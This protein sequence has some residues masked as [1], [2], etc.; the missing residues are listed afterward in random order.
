M[1]R[2]NIHKLETA[3]FDKCKKKKKQHY[4]EVLLQWKDGGPTDCVLQVQFQQTSQHVF[5]K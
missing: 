2:C 1:V 5:F 3:F 4:N